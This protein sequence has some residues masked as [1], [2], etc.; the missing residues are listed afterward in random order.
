MTRDGLTERP[1]GL[2]H[3]FELA[4]SQG[5]PLTLGK[6]GDMTAICYTRE[7][8]RWRYGLTINDAIGNNLVGVEG[9]APKVV[10]Q[11]IPYGLRALVRSALVEMARTNEGEL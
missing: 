10:I 5:T 11:G 7:D 2:E 9:D 8:V 1:S 4:V 3:E 6:A